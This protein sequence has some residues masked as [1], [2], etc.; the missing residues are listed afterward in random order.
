[1][2][3][4][5][6]ARP[7]T[8]RKHLLKSGDV[9][10]PDRLAPALQMASGRLIIEQLI[11]DG[12]TL[13][14]EIMLKAARYDF[15]RA[16]RF[17]EASLEEGIAEEERVAREEKASLLFEIASTR[18]ARAS[19][20]FHPKL[21]SIEHLAGPPSAVHE[22]LS[23]AVMALLDQLAEGRRKSAMII[24]QPPAGAGDAIPATGIRT[25]P[26]PVVL[27]DVVD[28]LQQ[29]LDANTRQLTHHIVED[30]LDDEPGEDGAS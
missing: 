2:A 16:E 4:Q 8:G 22:G 13:P 17:A 23:M 21:A 15:R 10:Q 28:R 1:M 12:Q 11:A 7:G 19:P 29:Q 14:A 27:E 3:A 30:V 25:A 9:E 6:G 20:Y 24:D 18:A 5:R 26:E